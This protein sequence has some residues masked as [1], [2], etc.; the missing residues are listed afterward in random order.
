LSK[1][2]IITERNKISGDGHFYR[3]W[4]FYKFL[5]KKNDVS[6]FLY[7]KKKKLPIQKIDKVLIDLFKNPE[8][9]A[10]F[11]K[12]RGIKVLT[13]ENFFNAKYD[14]NI[15]VY[16]HAK[17][18][19][20]NRKSGLKYCLIREKIFKLI[21]KNLKYIFVCLGNSEKIKQTR[22][23]LN[24]LKNQNNEV[25]I[26]SNFQEILSFEYKKNKNII[27]Y[28]K[29][30]FL[31]LFKNCDWAILN[32][33]LTLI[34]SIFMRKP[35]LSIPQSKYE[36]VFSKFLLKNFYILGVGLKSLN[37]KHELISKIRVNIKNVIDGNGKKRLLR[38][39]NRM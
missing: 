37:F 11:Y 19:K 33:G 4:D 21:K 8:K 23:I 2:L 24:I 36:L 26:I 18:I 1:I 31:R 28:Q 13:F 15:S 38:E 5:N 30:N 9:I 20:G 35:A 39:I 29:T 10:D 6:F 22:Y 17:K 7:S 3:M 12:N 32:G 25:K 14:V 27:F 16:D 34:E